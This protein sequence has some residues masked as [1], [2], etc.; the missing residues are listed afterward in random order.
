MTAI[1]VLA[2]FALP[3]LLQLSRVP[4][5]RVLRRD[6]GPPPPL[7]LLAFGPAVAVVLLLIYWVVR[8]LA[9]VPGLHRRA[10]GLRCCC[11]RWPAACWSYLAGRL[12]GRVGVAWRFGVANL[13]RRRAESVVQLVA[14]GT[15]IMVLLLL[16]ILRGDLNRDWR[17]TL[18][19]N[20]PNYFF[21]NIP[22]A[23]ARRLR[24]VPRRRRARAPRGCC[25]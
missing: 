22:P 19:A 11:W 23:S 24:A 21:I 2:G 16:G 6:V 25:R 1:A 8:E 12:R 5:L 15:G 20:L 9:H 4:A 3:P 13:S 7:V 17:R 14:F 10:R 18:P